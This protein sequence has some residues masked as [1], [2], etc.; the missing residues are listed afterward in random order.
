MAASELR[1][2]AVPVRGG[3]QRNQASAPFPAQ[4][5]GQQKDIAALNLLSSFR[6]ADVSTKIILLSRRC[7]GVTG[8]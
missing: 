2:H 3:S 6:P 1:K 5:C 7:E 8:Y 4:T